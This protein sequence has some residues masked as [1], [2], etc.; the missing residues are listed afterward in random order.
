MYALYKGEE[1]L[2]MGTIYQIAKE[3]NIKVKTVMYYKTKAY[4]RKI[5]KRKGKNARILVEV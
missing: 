4:K 5:A 3:Q 1:L 2:C